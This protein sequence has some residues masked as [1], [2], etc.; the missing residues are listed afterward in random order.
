VFEYKYPTRGHPSKE[1]A[2]INSSSAFVFFAVVT[3]QKGVNKSNNYIHKF[4]NTEH[5]Q[6]NF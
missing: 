3:S 2:A 6:C 1:E 4:S 5:Q